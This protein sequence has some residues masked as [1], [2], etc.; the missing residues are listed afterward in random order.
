MLATGALV[1]GMATVAI[2]LTDP[3]W[4]LKSQV[5]RNGPLALSVS[6]AAAGDNPEPAITAMPVGEAETALAAAPLMPERLAEPAAVALPEE[7]DAHILA[8]QMATAPVREDALELDRSDRIALQR[9]LALLGYDPQGVDG[10]LG[11]KSR[12]AIAAWQKDFGFVETGYLDA[13]LL[14]SI[15]ERSME[16]WAVWEAERN[17]RVRHAAKGNATSMEVDETTVEAGCA[18]GANG[19]IIERQSFICDIK[20]MTESVGQLFTSDE[21]RDPRLTVVRGF[22]R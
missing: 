7:Q 4:Q 12:E 2:S 19:T 9:R 10:V 21:D 6:E 14:A 18:R 13:P 16:Q 22:D 3:V 5:L 20:G 8:Y 11:P 15:K 17:A 1:L